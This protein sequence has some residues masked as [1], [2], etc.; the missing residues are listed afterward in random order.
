MDN[1][2]Y[3]TKRFKRVYDWVADLLTDIVYVNKSDFIKDNRW[4][5]QICSETKDACALILH[6]EEV[7]KR[8][9]AN[10]CEPIKDIKAYNMKWEIPEEILKEKQEAETEEILRNYRRKK[11]KNFRR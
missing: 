9:K 5:E 1:M 8:R 10:N 3:C 4:C 7:A 11:K 6:F 2:S